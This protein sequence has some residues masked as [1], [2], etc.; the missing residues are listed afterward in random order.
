MQ[1]KP[2]DEFNS[3]E[4]HGFSFIAVGPVAIGKRH[5]LIIYINNAIV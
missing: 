4:G 1:Q 3:V 5:L 2:S